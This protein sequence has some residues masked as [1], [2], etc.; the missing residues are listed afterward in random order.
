ME[1]VYL[2]FDAWPEAD[3]AAWK[4]AIAV[5]DILDDQGPAAHWEPRTKQTNIQHYSRWLGYLNSTV[6]LANL[7]ADRVTKVRVHAYIRHLEAKVAPRTMVSSLVGLKVI[8]KAMAPAHDWHWL[9]DVCNRLNRNAKP[10]RDKRSRILHSGTMFRM[11][12]DYLQE[13]SETDL[14]K[15][16]QLV[17]F[18]NG[19]MVALMTAC[20]L[21][22]K[23]FSGLTIGTTFKQVGDSW[24]IRI[25]AADTKNKQPLELYV[26]QELSMHIQTYLN[27]VRK[28]IANAT[29]NAVWVSW[30]GDQM[31]CHMVYVA[32]TRITTTLFGR[33]INPH[34]F[35]DSAATTLATHSLDAVMAAPGLLGHMNP[36]TTAKHYIHASGINASR[37]MNDILMCHAKGAK[38]AKA[39]PY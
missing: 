23:N 27:R 13:L 26:P 1:K 38:W 32:F 34:L 11:A 16:K 2:P 22:R 3:K 29:E 21:R 6:G 25:P 35:R 39:A 18:R 7:P 8:V 4:V 20:P 19:L 31:P 15:R 37:K 28:R 24:I 30:D 9:A 36:K 33:S 17:G 14:S 5:G 10:I 12:L